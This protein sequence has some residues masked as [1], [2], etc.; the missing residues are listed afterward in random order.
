MEQ[1]RFVWYQSNAEFTVKNYGQGR[2]VFD[3]YGAGTLIKDNTQQRERKTCIQSFAEFIEKKAFS[4]DK[5]TTVM[6]AL[7]T[8]ALVVKECQ[9]IQSP[10]NAEVGIVR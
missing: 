5:N 4:Y 6:I 1:R 8:A 10:G 7:I 2:V 3:G 9:T